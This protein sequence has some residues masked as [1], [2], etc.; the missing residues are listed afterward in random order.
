MAD[1]QFASMMATMNPQQRQM[2]MQQMQQMQMA[3]NPYMTNQYG[4]PPMGMP[5]GMGGFPGGASVYAT[6]M[7]PSSAPVMPKPA[8]SA[9][10]APA[11][12]PAPRRG[13]LSVKLKPEERGVYSSLYDLACPKGT[14]KIDGRDAAAF[15]KKSSLPKGTLKQI[16][17][18]A[19]QTNVASMSRD[20]FY[21]ALKLVAL[22]Q[23]GKE[24]SA[25]AILSDHD[26]PI[27]HFDSAGAAGAG[28][29]MG[30][31]ATMGYDGGMG[32]YSAYSTAMPSSASSFDEDRYSMSDKELEKYIKVYGNVDAEQKGYLTSEQMRLVM[33]RTHLPANVTSALCAM[34]DEQGNGTFPKPIAIIA[35]HL[36][37]LA[38][39]K[40]PLPRTVPAELKRKL[41]SQLGGSSARPVT[42][43]VS[44]RTEA[45]LESFGKPSM[46][47]GYDQSSRA[48]AGAR[49][50]PSAVAV[51][52]D[53][54][55][56]I[57]KEVDE[58]RVEINDLRE[59]ES[60]LKSKVESL[61]ERNKTLAAQLQKVKDE[62]VAAQKSVA[63]QKATPI[64]S[65]SPPA[66]I[67][68]GNRLSP[69]PAMSAPAPAPT[70]YQPSPT[71]YEDPRRAS[72]AAPPVRYAAP[73]APVQTMAPAAR[74]AFAPNVAPAAPAFSYPENTANNF[75]PPVQRPAPPQ[76]QAPSAPVA[77]AAPQYQPQ[78]E[79]KKGA[80]WVSFDFS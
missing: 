58:R 15:L 49:A 11:A 66:P 76:F 61:R 47:P 30:M 45:S 63:A 5:G 34:C 59:E 16:W 42:N 70:R 22:A 10:V 77:Q 12:A 57:K 20:E 33:E 65:P 8:E 29:G 80:E 64:P 68:D 32:G 28:M 52:E 1:P 78:P 55:A 56:V 9:V 6:N 27:P 44:A 60:D 37:V 35:L 19:A 26:A 62:L 31:G 46:T 72:P 73:Q 53:V 43:S 39:K 14:S 36:A 21:V 23:T 74:P 7:Y 38:V 79:A 67:M 54:V 75:A 40:V 71:Q 25:Q 17:E 51:G 3:S 69:P 50:G 2:F 41:T 4:A 24:V 48:A 13:K 18:I